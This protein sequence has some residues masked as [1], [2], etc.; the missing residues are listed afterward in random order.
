MQSQQAQIDAQHLLLIPE[1]RKLHRK[2]SKDVWER[3][4]T[5][6]HVCSR[7][8]PKAPFFT[9]D[10][11]EI[12]ELARRNYFTGEVPYPDAFT[13]LVDEGLAAYV[14]AY[15]IPEV[16]MVRIF[17]DK[18]D[19]IRKLVKDTDP[20]IVKTTN[21]TTGAVSFSSNVD[22]LTK[23]MEKID[24]LMATKERLEAK[25]RRESEGRGTARGGKKPS[26]LERKQ[27]QKS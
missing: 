25:I 2:F 22:I 7:L 5:Y 12:R 13:D 21:P 15:E 19:Q 18:I 23:S 10:E 9:A 11:N 26:R 4:I 14:K 8:D 3:V 17:N 1:L 16:R 24:S 20:E 6:I 27:M